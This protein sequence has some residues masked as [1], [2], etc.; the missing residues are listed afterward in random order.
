MYPRFG[1]SIFTRL[2]SASA[3]VALTASLC[4]LPALAE[5][6]ADAIAGKLATDK[7]GAQTANDPEAKWLHEEARR[8][9]ERALALENDA[10]KAGGA[11]P[12]GDVAPMGQE[13][14]AT[15]AVQPKAG[16]AVSDTSQSE[17]DD[18]PSASIPEPEPDPAKRDAEVKELS[19]RLRDLRRKRDAERVEALKAHPNGGGEGQDGKVL[20]ELATGTPS[21]ISPLVEKTVSILIVMDVGKSGLRS[22]SKTADPMLCIHESCYLSRGP[23]KSAEKLTRRTAFGPSVALGKRGQAC[24]SKPACIFRTI[25]LET[26]EA[27]LQP[28]DLRFLRHDRREAKAIRADTTCGIFEGQLSCRAPIH[29]K[30]WTAWIVPES[31]AARAGASGL[32]AAM[33]KGLE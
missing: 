29:G 6:A 11:S 31:V 25:D 24:R 7:S 20:S 22:W 13:D 1:S 16:E 30:G 14:S 5:G 17:P 32:E 28:V 9:V 27:K 8:A 19:E 10:K 33:A 26:V 12:A 15:G 18:P 23:Q 21:Y 2:L 3:V 4:A